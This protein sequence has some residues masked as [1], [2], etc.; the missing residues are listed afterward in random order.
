MI[1]PI[2]NR[3]TVD[4]WS[5]RVCNKSES[6]QNKGIS[7]VLDKIEGLIKNASMTYCYTNALSRFR[8][9][10]WYLIR[11]SS[12]FRTRDMPQFWQFSDLFQTFSDRISTVSRS[13]IITNMAYCCSNALRKFRRRFWYPIRPSSSSS[14]RVM[15]FQST[16]MSRF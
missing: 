5:E 15:Q 10:F 4:F 16:E 11:P 1:V 12:L 2:F 7:G 8:R 3:Q 9:R 13:N 14:T 6:C